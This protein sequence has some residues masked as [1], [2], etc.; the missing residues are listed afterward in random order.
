MSQFPVYL[1][2]IVIDASNRNIRFKEGASTVT[3]QLTLGTYYLLGDG[4]AGDFLA[5]LRARL[6][7]ATASANTYGITV[8]RSIAI[9]SATATVTIA[10]LA[11]S[12]T[13]QFLWANASTT[14]DAGL[15]GFPQV[16]TLDNGNAKVSTLS[17]S[18][19]WV[20]PE[21][22]RSVEQREAAD[23]TVTRTRSSLTA[24]Q[25]V[26]S[27]TEWTFEHALIHEQRAKRKEALLDP[28]R[29]A[30]AFVRRWNDGSLLQVHLTTLATSTELA[31]IGNSTI[32]VKGCL[33]Q[34][35]SEEFEPRRLQPGVPFYS[36][37]LTILDDGTAGVV[38]GV[39]P[40]SAPSLYWPLD[41]L[42]SLITAPLT[43][44]DVSGN[45]RN[46]AAGTSGGLSRVAGPGGTANKALAYSGFGGSRF[47]QTSGSS[48]AHFTGATGSGSF[49]CF[50]KTNPAS[51]CDIG[52]VW[53]EAGGQRQWRMRARTFGVTLEFFDN[54]GA[55]GR[56]LTAAAAVTSASVWHSVAFTWQAATDTVRIYFNGAE[57]AFTAAVTGANIT[58]LPASTAPFQAFSVFNA[59][60]A[61][62]AVGEMAHVFVSDQVWTPTEIAN[63]IHAVA[64][65]DARIL[66]L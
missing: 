5:E 28:F 41:D 36:F 40:I 23:V 39:V 62:Q 44:T 9:A 63:Q 43:L 64:A 46:G 15:I 48:L 7:A 16:D 52:G 49:F 65:A 25:R 13:F 11:G 33:D 54:A 31:P 42:T 22:V 45:G 59:A 12:D 21:V 37:A 10:R 53:D 61:S 32:K 20:S 47:R 56:T 3:V 2:P 55:N 38:V 50:I 26:G 6:E 30:S 14:F 24:A 57:V 29:A 4:T 18:S 8:T 58:Q 35:S 60:G 1:A 27:H 51:S 66:G 19:S 17:P 34:R